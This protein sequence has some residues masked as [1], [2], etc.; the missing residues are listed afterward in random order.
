MNLRICDSGHEQI[1]PASIEL[2]ERAFASDA[3]IRD[4]TEIALAEGERWIAALAVGT[5]GGPD[6]FLVTGADGEV[7]VP[8][9]KVARAEALRRFREFM[10]A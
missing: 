4:A 5:P 9:G 8:S 6:E 1:L 10:S 3:P 2:V 7:P